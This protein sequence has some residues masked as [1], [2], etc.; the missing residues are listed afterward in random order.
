MDDE[1]F[2]EPKTFKSH[3]FCG[4]GDIES[5]HIPG[6]GEGDYAS[7]TKSETVEK[8]E[9]KDERVLDIPGSL[10]GRKDARFK[11]NG[12][13]VKHNLIPFG[14]GDHLV[15]SSKIELI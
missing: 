10:I 6:T 9:V 5:V 13:A 4:A 3:R 14:G 7:A 12:V 1:I 8:S 15:F 2:P 11:K